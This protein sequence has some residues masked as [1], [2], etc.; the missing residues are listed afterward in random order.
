MKLNDLCFKTKILMI[1]LK[2]NT[3]CLYFLIISIILFIV[4]SGVGYSYFSSSILQFSFPIDISVMF[5]CGIGI[6]LLILFAIALYFIYPRFFIH[7]VITFPTYIVVN[8][9]YIVYCSPSKS[10]KY[11]NN[12]SSQWTD[13]ITIRHLQITQNCCGW[14]NES[15]RGLLYCPLTFT[16]GCINILNDYLRPRFHEMYVSSFVML[17]LH[18]FSFLV[19]TLGVFCSGATSVLD[20]VWFP[21]L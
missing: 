1:C 17:T 15:D 19:L 20:I 2:L 9:L 12:W 3:I 7:Y 10:E 11:V 16:S 4:I 14:E 18:V 8:I 5:G 6:G 21:S 13:S